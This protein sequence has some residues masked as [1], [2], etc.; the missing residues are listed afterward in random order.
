MFW[1]SCV[2]LCILVKVFTI[3]IC[4]TL[5]IG[6]WKWNNKKKLSAIF[7]TREQENWYLLNTNTSGAW[8]GKRTTVLARWLAFIANCYKQRADCNGVVLPTMWRILYSLSTA[9]VTASSVWAKFCAH[10]ASVRIPSFCTNADKTWLENTMR[11]SIWDRSWLRGMW[12]EVTNMRVGT[13]GSFYIVATNRDFLEGTGI[14]RNVHSP[15]FHT[16][17]LY[18]S[19]LMWFWQC[20]VVNMWK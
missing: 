14:C 3:F 16:K 9:L 8:H 12:A 10:S 6:P 19:N 1:Y 13:N 4:I 5:F 20:I 11:K 17:F 15:Y 2:I 18:H 7:S